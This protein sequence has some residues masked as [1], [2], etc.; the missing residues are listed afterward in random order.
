MYTRRHLAKLALAT[1]LAAAVAAPRIDSKIHGVMIGAQ[2]YSFRDIQPRNIETCIDAYKQT[3]LGYC[4]LSAGHFEPQDKQELAA[5]R[6]NPPL[7]K[8]A[9][10]RKKFDAA[11][12]VLYAL[13]YSFREEWSDDEIENGFKIAKAMGLNKITA[14]SNVSTAKRVDPLAEKYKIYVGMHNHSRIAPNEFATPDNFDAALKGMS[15]YIAINLDIGHFTAA[16]F[17][18]VEYLEQHHDRI[19][20]LHLKDRKKNQGPNT[21][22]GEGDTDIKSVLKLL[23]T[24]K[25]PIPAMIEYEYKGPAD[26]VTE[27]KRCYEYCKTAL[28]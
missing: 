23:E 10:I 1:P 25:Y 12:I 11:G 18:P 22:F 26:P 7:D 19:V 17:N 24:K 15:K 5:W 21:P 27:V 6:K 2:S 14:S 16:G 3:G 28:G 8:L 20:T 13:N 4:E 9:Q